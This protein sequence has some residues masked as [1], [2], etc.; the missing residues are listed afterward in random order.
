[1]W[2]V[3]VHTVCLPFE[4]PNGQLKLYYTTLLTKLTL[5]GHMSI[6]TYTT[7]CM[8]CTGAP[9]HSTRPP[10]CTTWCTHDFPVTTTTNCTDTLY[11]QSTHAR[12]HACTHAH[13]HARM[14]A[15]THTY[16]CKD[17]NCECTQ[18]KSQNADTSISLKQP[19]SDE[20]VVR[21]RTYALT[22]LGKQ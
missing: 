5:V 6:Y 8:Y 9:W 21:I 1:M 18:K 3:Y 11:V 22:Q 13:T 4:F 14:H 2:D 16:T 12:T 17:R 20:Y 10:A 19:L 15:R 7:I